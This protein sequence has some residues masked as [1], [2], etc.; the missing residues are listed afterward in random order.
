[1]TD[2]G[3]ADSRGTTPL[4]DSGPQQMSS[5]TSPIVYV[6]DDDPEH[7]LSLESL[8]RSVSLDVKTYENADDFLQDLPRDPAGCALLDVRLPGMSGIELHTEM[9]N[10]GIELPVLIMTG[11]GDIPSVVTAF[12]HGALDF[13]QKPYSPNGLINRIHSALRKDAETRANRRDRQ[14]IEEKIASL[15]RRERE[16]MLQLI[17]GRSTKQIAMDLDVGLT[18]V[19]FHRT[20]L[21]DKMGFESVPVLIREVVAHLGAD[22]DEE[23]NSRG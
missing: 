4:N 23:G 8:M 20:N 17:D 16:V 6:V 11:Y 10:A 22:L 7:R 21:L 5:Q 13:I 18:T 1:M 15:T 12:Q 3:H 9:V 2:S 14:V 19:D